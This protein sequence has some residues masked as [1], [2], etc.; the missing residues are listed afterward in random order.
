MTLV[1]RPL[2]RLVAFL[3]LL[4]VSLAGLAVAVFSISGGSG[5]LSLTALAQLLHLP[6][7]REAVGSF[8]VGAE[9]GDRPLQAVAGGVVAM[10]AGVLLLVGALARRAE[11][12]LVFDEGKGGR[13]LARRAALARVALDL[14]SGAGGVTGARVRVRPRRR[15]PGGRIDIVASHPGSQTGS[16]IHDRTTEAL[17]PL[18]E[19]SGQ[20]KTRVRPRTGEKGTRAE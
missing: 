13:I 12:V 6:G 3:L 9:V 5:G 19:G 7:L 1:L 2:A 14:A 11:R 17:K 10:L 16:D 15:R 8:L 4:A 20:L 18:S